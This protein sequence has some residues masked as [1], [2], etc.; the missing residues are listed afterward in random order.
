MRIL[1]AGAGI[2][3]PTLAWWLHRYGF[4]PTIVEK[5]PALRTGGYI[6]DFWGA[7]YEIAGRMGLLPE[8]Q[9]VGYHVREVRIVNDRGRRISG[10]NT[11]A[12][13]RM[14]DGNFVSLGRGDLAA[15][16][17]RL[18]EDKVETR[19]GDSVRSIVEHDN[20][21]QVEFESGVQQEF[22]LVMGADGLH[23]QVRNLV[24]GPEDQYEKYLGCKAAAFTAPGYEP[25][26]ELIYLMYSQ[27]GGQVARFSMRDGRTMF[28]FTFAD[29]DPAIGALADQKRQLH[30]RFGDS[31]WECSRILAALDRA[32]QLY[33]DRV[34][35]IRMG[36]G[37]GAWHR[38]RV[39]LLGDAASCISFLGGQGSALAMTAAYLLAGELRRCQGDYH[40][41]F[42]A[43]ERRF[44]P[45]VLRKQKA[46]LRF[47]GT[48]VP[49]SRPSILLRN[50]VMKMMNWGPIADMIVRGDLA[51]RLDL[52]NFQSA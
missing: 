24:F 3:G 47:S 22:D 14:T 35:Q 29:D 7:G 49:R 36:T 4:Q 19:F 34:S 8:L 31:G 39:A 38:G 23:S 6:I 37:E 1:I 30:S 10:F 27:V 45:F 50:L 11:D 21:V 17:F 48:F 28:L 2:A 18:I 46:A 43:Y 16:I 25:R 9:R 13:W 40:E 20:A 15:A 32:D 5:S 44:S 42:R 33:F 41:A 26:D 52:S 12:F 51:D